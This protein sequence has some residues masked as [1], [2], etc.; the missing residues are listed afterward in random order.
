MK[1]FK[2]VVSLLMAVFFY[3]SF[4]RPLLSTEILRDETSTIGFGQLK[5]YDMRVPFVREVILE[6]DV[7]SGPPVSVFLVET[8]SIND[9]RFE[10]IPSFTVGRASEAETDSIV[11]PGYW[12]ILILP[13]SAGESVVKVKTKLRRPRFFRRPSKSQPIKELTAQSR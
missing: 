2:T 10:G 12:S 1:M 11:E 4:L 7:E 8:E 9:Y 3:G 13:A 6:F 5:A